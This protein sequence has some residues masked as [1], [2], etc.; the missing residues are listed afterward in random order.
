MRIQDKINK[1]RE[2]FY[3][4][5]KRKPTS[6]IL[7]YE[8]IAEMRKEVPSRFIDPGAMLYGMAVIV[9]M[10]NPTRVETGDFET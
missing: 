4:G 5:H 7:G 3:L 8:I 1:S 10:N 9:D 2:A 6:I